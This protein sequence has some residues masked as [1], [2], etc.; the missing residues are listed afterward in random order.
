[1]DRKIDNQTIAILI[2]SRASY[3]YINSNIVEIFYLQ[4]SKNRKYWLVQ[5][6][7]WAKMKINELVEYFSIVMNGINT[8]VDVNIIP[9]V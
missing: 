9:L 6:V 3:S 5:L 2:D 7:T 8:E 4:K 1:V